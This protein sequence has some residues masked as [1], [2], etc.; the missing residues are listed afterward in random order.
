VLHTG[1]GTFDLL[2]RE[3][4]IGTTMDDQQVSRGDQSCDIVELAESQYSGNCVAVTVMDNPVLTDESAEGAACDGNGNPP[5]A[6]G[7]IERGHSTA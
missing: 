2:G 1:Y 7:G 4:G 5:I 3:Q 6:C